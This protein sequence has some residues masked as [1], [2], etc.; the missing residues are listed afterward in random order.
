MSKLDEPEIGKYPDDT[1]G[2][3]LEKRDRKENPKSWVRP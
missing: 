3:D 1:L 2:Y